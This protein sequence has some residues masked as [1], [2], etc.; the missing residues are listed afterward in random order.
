M[1]TKVTGATKDGEDYK[2]EIEDVKSG[3]K[4]TLDADVI[5]VAVGRKPF[6]EG[7]GL[8]NI[9]IE[10]DERG[11]VPVDDHLKTSYK[12]VPSYSRIASIMY[13]QLVML[14]EDLC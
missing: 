4:S 6:T 9:G 5:L 1:G 12:L 13:M 2:V 14:L 3:K 7:L 8:E 11:R 10:L